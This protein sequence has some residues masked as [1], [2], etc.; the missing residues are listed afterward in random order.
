ML[1]NLVIYAVSSTDYLIA[2]S[3]NPSLKSIG[4]C[5]FPGRGGGGPTPKP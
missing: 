5:V 4:S 1:V 3:E 2:K